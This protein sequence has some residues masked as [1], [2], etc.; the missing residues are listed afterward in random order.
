MKLNKALIAITLCAATVSSS[1]NAQSV[2]YDQ[3]LRAYFGP[4]IEDILRQQ[5]AALAQD[6]KDAFEA[7]Y[8][9]IN[10]PTLTLQN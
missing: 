6:L 2:D 1:A 4:S 9:V 5:N 8:R 3:I 10:Q 7:Y